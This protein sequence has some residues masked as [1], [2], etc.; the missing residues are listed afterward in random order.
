ME[1]FKRTETR[2]ILKHVSGKYFRNS[3]F[4]TSYDAFLT[5]DIMQATRFT[6]KEIADAVVKRNKNAEF[7]YAG[8]FMLSTTLMDC[9]VVVF[10]LNIEGKVHD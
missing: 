7:K 6:T 3:V 9:S 8:E 5:D 4:A 10:E 2:Y 1:E